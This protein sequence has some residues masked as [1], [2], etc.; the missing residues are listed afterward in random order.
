VPRIIDEENKFCKTK[1][2]YY[3]ILVL[4]VKRRYYKMAEKIRRLCMKE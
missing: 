3:G 1:I 2:Y 4:V